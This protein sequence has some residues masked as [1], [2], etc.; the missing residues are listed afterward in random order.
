MKKVIVITLYYLVLFSTVDAADHVNVFGG[1]P[2]PGYTTT[3]PAAYNNSEASLIAAQG[4]YAVDM[5]QA[6]VN[7]QVGYSMALD[8]HL[9]KI[10]TFFIGRVK[11]GY[12]RDMEAWRKEEK[13]RLKRTGQ[14]NGDSIRQLYMP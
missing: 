10:D 14:W 13:T 4:G 9:K 3:A 5:S 8:N 12:Y 1:M 2:F 6:F 7:S 11:N